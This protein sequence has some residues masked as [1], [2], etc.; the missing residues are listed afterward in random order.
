MFAKLKFQSWTICFHMHLFNFTKDCYWS[1]IFS[2]S[3]WASLKAPCDVRNTLKYPETVYST[4][5]TNWSDGLDCAFHYVRQD[6]EGTELQLCS[7]LARYHIGERLIYCT[8]QHCTNKVKKL[9]SAMEQSNTKRTHIP[10]NFFK[11]FIL[12][13][14]ERA[15]APWNNIYT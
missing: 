4:M 15:T 2:I 8:R 5:E 10:W 9:H 7:T 1:L 3:M 13:L 14:F 12:L 6:R 11:D